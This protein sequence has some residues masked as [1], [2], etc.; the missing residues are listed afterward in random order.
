[1]GRVAKGLLLLLPASLLSQALLAS[2]GVLSA[3]GLGS[4]VSPG[5]LSR[6]HAKL[7]GLDNCQKCHEPGKRVTAQKCLECHKPIAEETAAKKGVHRDAGAACARCHTEH[8]GVAA[9]IRHLDTRTFDHRAETGFA[10]D[11]K[12]A[13]LDCGKC[14]K[15]RS[16]LTAKPD[17]ASCHADPHKGVLGASCAS[18]HPVAVAFKETRTSFDHSKTAY[19]LTGAHVTTACE[20]CHVAKVWKGIRFASCASCHKDPHEKPLGTCSSCHTT[21][22]FRYVATTGASGGKAGG[23]AVAAGATAGTAA[24]TGAAATAAGTTTAPPMPKF[25][26]AKTGYPLVGRH[27]A[28]ACTTCHVRP[29]TTVHLKYARCDDCHKDP[30]KGVFKTQ[31]CAACHKVTGWKGGTFDHAKTRFPLEGKHLPVPCASC[32]KGAAVPPR[33]VPAKV[34]VDFRGVRADC[35]SCHEDVHKKEL[36]TTCETCHSPVGWRLETFRHPRS[37]EFFAGGHA[38]VTCDK[39]HGIE[40]SAGSVTLPKGRIVPVRRYKGVS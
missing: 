30:H 12:H 13:G 17:C 15:T 10:L 26:H 7:E 38:T 14:H 21:A 16:F 5:P 29:A 4:L 27:A 8:T 20:K 37:P 3:Q 39:C 36:G 31:D 35:A 32:H 6:A 34:V 25:D 22:T 18:C 19:P 9:D 2:P 1:M 40:A 28:L 33:A 24:G 11:G 23:A